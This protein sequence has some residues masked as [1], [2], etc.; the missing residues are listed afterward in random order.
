MVAWR[1]V[2]YGLSGVPPPPPRLSWGGGGPPLALGVVEGRR[3]LGPS[4]A[5]R[6]PEGGEWVGEDEGVAPCFLAT[7][8]RFPGPDPRRLQGSGL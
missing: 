6:G 7:L 5:S 4:P 3:P 2:A 8:L 1:R